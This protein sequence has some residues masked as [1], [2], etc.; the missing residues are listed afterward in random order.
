MLV[1]AKAGNP[2][3]GQEFARCA[4]L[5]AVVEE[6]R[7]ERQGPATFAEAELDGSPECDENRRHVA[8]RR[9]V[10]NVA[11]DRADC[12]HLLRTQAIEH[13]AD[14]RVDAAK[15]RLRFG[16]RGGGA[17]LHPVVLFTHGPKGGDAP[18]VNDPGQ[19]TQFLRDP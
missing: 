3:P 12:P 1:R 9:A 11:A 15:R 4:V 7:L 18:G 10:R 13:F 14:I 16:V 2:D 19:V 8:Y 17:K 6:E 5:N